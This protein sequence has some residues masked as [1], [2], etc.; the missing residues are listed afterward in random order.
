MSEHQDR[1]EAHLA[2][3]LP[4][5]LT[6]LTIKGRQLLAIRVATEEIGRLLARVR[7]LEAKLLE[8]EDA[9]DLFR[10]EIMQ[11]HEEGE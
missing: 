4:T 6:P 11:H 3:L 8:A 9:R 5:F 2:G 1:G 7:E 10:R